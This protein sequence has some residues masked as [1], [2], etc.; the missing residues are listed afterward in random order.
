MAALQVKDF[1]TF[2]GKI[3]SNSLFTKTR[4]WPISWAESIYSTQQ[5][6]QAYLFTITLKLSSHLRLGIASGHFASTFSYHVRCVA[7][8]ER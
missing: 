4:Y 2:G 6:S 7:R 5:Q 8:L 1:Y 3:T